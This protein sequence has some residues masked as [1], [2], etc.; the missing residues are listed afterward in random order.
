M[1]PLARLRLSPQGQV[2]GLEA[3]PSLGLQGYPGI[4]ALR[5]EPL[6][7]E[8]EARLQALEE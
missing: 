7:Q 2:V 5:L 4:V 1:R 6:F 3:D 8:A